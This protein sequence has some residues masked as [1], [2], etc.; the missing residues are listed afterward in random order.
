MN[1]WVAPI[2][3]CYCTPPAFFPCPPLTSLDS[4]VEIWLVR[5]WTD[6]SL[7]CLEPVRG[8]CCVLAL[9]T[10][11]KD[12][13]QELQEFNKS[14]SWAFPLGG[15]IETLLKS[16]LIDQ[17]PSDL[18][19]LLVTVQVVRSPASQPAVSQALFPVGTNTPCPSQLLGWLSL[20]VDSLLYWLVLNSVPDSLPP[21]YD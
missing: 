7:H 8:L 14:G 13:F 3:L 10:H 15:S 20:G 2:S 5:R 19:D 6:H 12:S 1:C 11:S 16:M 4:R 21:Q 17:D 18:D 9:S